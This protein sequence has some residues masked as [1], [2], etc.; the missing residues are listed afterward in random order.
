MGLPAGLLGT[1]YLI[2]M[3]GMVESGDMIGQSNRLDLDGYGTIS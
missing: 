2:D 1:G 3:D